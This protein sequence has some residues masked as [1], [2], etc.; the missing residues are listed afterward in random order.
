MNLFEE[1]IEKKELLEFAI[2][3][4]KYYVVDRDYGSHS[5]IGSWI[6]YILP[7]VETKG[8]GYVN[9]SIEN[10]I[11]ELTFAENIEND[12]RN[13]MLLNH[14]HVYYYLV[15]EKRVVAIN[16]IKLNTEIQHIF[17]L[18]LD[19]LEKLNDSKIT[20]IKDTIA[21]IKSRGGLDLSS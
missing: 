12:I 3:K 7:L 5:I 21:L 16:M 8:V 11:K 6:N 20:A 18:Y 2:G 13:E 19:E 4:G 17:D 15:E 1:A 14:L 10:M 9:N